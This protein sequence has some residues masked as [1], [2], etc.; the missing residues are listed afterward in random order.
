MQYKKREC[1]IRD[2][3]EPVINNAILN[4][5]LNK[6]GVL[7]MRKVCSIIATIRIKKALQFTL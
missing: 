1:H 6:K 5:C 2:D 3:M 7:Q 4:N